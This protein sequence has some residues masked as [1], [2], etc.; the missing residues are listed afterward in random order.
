MKNLDDFLQ[1]LNK[2]EN[3]KTQNEG[4][5]SRLNLPKDEI[6]PNV[7]RSYIPN[8]LYLEPFDTSKLPIED[9][10]DDTSLY[11]HS[12]IK[13]TEGF[14]S[15]L[16]MRKKPLRSYIVVAPSNFGK[17]FFA[18]SCIKTC[19]E[20]GLQPSPI[21]LLRELEEMYSNKAYKE[22]RDFILS[23]DILFLSIG[24]TVDKKLI[25]VLGFVLEY[26]EIYATPLVVLSKF[27]VNYLALFEPTIYENIGLQSTEARRY[28][29]L[30]RIG[31]PDDI[32]KKF[33]NQTVSKIK[34][35]T[36]VSE[37][38]GTAN[39]LDISESQIEIEEDINF[40]DFESYKEKLKGEKD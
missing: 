26:A 25:E 14:L 39:Y 28:G 13:S 21:V 12:Y 38:E 32:M 1:S 5:K 18:Y 23:K 24:N 19:L 34:G 33:F 15:T 37:E 11:M 8:K 4:Y 7:L 31:F 30:K 29:Q 10:N 9:L 27:P 2:S 3:P 6:P 17:K 36:P 40:D 16:E 35:K 20:Y 22:I